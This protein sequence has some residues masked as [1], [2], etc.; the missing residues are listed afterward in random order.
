VYF[1]TTQQNP[2]ALQHPNWF[3]EVTNREQQHSGDNDNAVPISEHLRYQIPVDHRLHSESES[4]HPSNNHTSQTRNVNKSQP[5]ATSPPKPTTESMAATSRL[6]VNEYSG[7]GTAP[8]SSVNS[9][10]LA[11]SYTDNP[12]FQSLLLRTIPSNLKKTAYISNHSDNSQVSNNLKAQYNEGTTFIESDMSDELEDLVNFR[13]PFTRALPQ[14]SLPSRTKEFSNYLGI[15]NGHNL[16][17]SLTE[18]KVPD[19]YNNNSF[20]QS[21]TKTRKLLVST[22]TTPHSVEQ[23]ATTHTNINIS[24]NEDNSN[25]TVELHLQDPRWMFFIPES[26]KDITDSGRY[27]FETGNVTVLFIS[28]PVSSHNH[29]QS[30]MHFRHD[31]D[32]TNNKKLDCP[33]CHP[34]FLLPG[35]CQPC[36]IIR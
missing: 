26:N 30:I 36:V 19:A 24:E 35:R 10:T 14:Q 12:F 9:Q 22:S 3:P 34:H 4:L 18:Q 7:T 28:I 23:R 13:I 11:A 16:P 25:N 2:G 21:L 6:V 20:F 15:T 29:G 1:F 31:D 27:N 17:A 33:R 5:H 8:N 32:V